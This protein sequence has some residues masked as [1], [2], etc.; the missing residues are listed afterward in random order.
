MDKIHIIEE[1]LME[2]RLSTSIRSIY[3]LIRHLY[4]TIWVIVL[5]PSVSLAEALFIAEAHHRAEHPSIK[6]ATG[7]HYSP[8]IDDKLPNGGWSVSIVQRVLEKLSV[9]A[10]IIY[11]PWDRA[12]KWTNEGQIF[13]SFPFV[14]SPQRAET[15]L[16]SKPINHVPVYMYVAQNSEFSTLESLTTK[17]LCFPYDYALSSL[18]KDIVNKYAMTINRVK[19]G[20]GCIKHVLKGWSDAGLINSYIDISKLSAVQDEEQMIKVF[21]QQ[22]ALV[23]LHFVISKQGKDSQLWID[24]F[25]QALAQIDSNGERAIIDNQYRKLLN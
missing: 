10:E 13:G 9:Q 12:L 14:Y 15:L 3:G 2:L 18:E 1:C 23:P 7:D 25:D 16:F 4:W 20:T 5:L 17:R 24:K 22:L 11:L 8:F 19:D 6:I 21:A